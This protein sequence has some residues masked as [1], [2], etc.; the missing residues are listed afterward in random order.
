M[1]NHDRDTMGT[2][3]HPPAL[4]YPVTSGKFIRRKRRLCLAAA[5]L[6]S[7]LVLAADAGPI[8]KHLRW[9]MADS[10]LENV[11]RADQ[12]YAGKYFGGSATYITGPGDGLQYQIP[13][14]WNSLPVANYKSYSLFEQHVAAGMVDKRV[15]WVKYNPEKWSLTPS[16]E[17]RDPI[18]YMSKFCALAHANNYRCIVAP[19]RDLLLVE[20]A[21]CEKR[22]GETLNQTYLRCGLASSASHG[23]DVVQIQGQANQIRPADYRSF[24]LEATAQAKGADR[25]TTLIANLTTVLNGVRQSPCTLFEA[26]SAV[27]DIVDGYWLNI[28]RDTG[29]TVVRFLAS[30]EA[31]RCL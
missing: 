29:S 28:P 6:A 17:Q 5:T 26:Y 27:E 19:S 21:V 18:T 14:G 4:I 3:R 22:T 30:I 7:L 11:R 2:S 15:D 12:S 20:G 10:S 31:G 23:A 16:N 24:M 13:A 1:S 25:S 9:G 8:R